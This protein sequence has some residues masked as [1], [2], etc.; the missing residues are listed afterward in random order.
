M[1]AW[2]GL[3]GACLTSIMLVLES[4]WVSALS[5]AH[6]TVSIAVFSPE[7]ESC[8]IPSVFGDCFLDSNKNKM[9]LGISF[10]IQWPSA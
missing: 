7:Q 10:A 4:H 5:W 8:F 6:V 9:F 2:H 1:E 3:C